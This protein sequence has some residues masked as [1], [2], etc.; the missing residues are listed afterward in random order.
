L[1]GDL[2]SFTAGTKTVSSAGT[3]VQVTTVP[4][5]VRRV[6]FQ[7]PPGNSGIT[8]VG[9]SDVSSSVA[10]IEFTAAGGNETVDFT[11]GRPGDLS[12]FYCDAATN[13]DKIHY[14]AVLV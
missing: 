5:P 13:G 14:M 12:E 6:R 11:E 3:R 8:Y 7:A 4:T 9:G 2:A 1:E 10:A